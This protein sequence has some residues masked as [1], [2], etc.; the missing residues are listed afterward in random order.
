VGP[1]ITSQFGS[2][3]AL[4]PEKPCLLRLYNFCR[5]L[6]ID[7]SLAWKELIENGTVRK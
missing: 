2:T 7:S 4:K 1:R 3:E 5:A 6:E